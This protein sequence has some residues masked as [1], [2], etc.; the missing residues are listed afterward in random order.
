MASR[1]V[2]IVQGSFCQALCVVSGMLVSKKILLVDDHPLFMEGIAAILADLWPGVELLRAT[3]AAAA[4]S[5]ALAHP[6]LDLVLFDYQ[7]PDGNGLALLRDFRAARLAVPAVMISAFDD[8]ALIDAALELGACGFIPKSADRSTYRLCLQ[9][10]EN[11][12]VFLLPETRRQLDQHRGDARVEKTRIASCLSPRQHEV[13]L[14]VATGYSNR[15]IGTALGIS[16]STVK[17]HMTQLLELFD[18]D[19]RAHCVAEARRLKLVS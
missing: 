16:E 9:Q 3:S 17:S 12:D 14:L 10:I 8:I 13:L 18:A 2:E 6:D 19:N 7:L 4:R 11:G 15:E 1:P 5:I